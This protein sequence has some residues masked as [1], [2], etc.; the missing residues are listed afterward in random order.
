MENQEIMTKD[1]HI[2]AILVSYGSPIT[3]VDRTDRKKQVFYFTCLPH[4][5]FI[6]GEIGPVI[7]EISV[8]DDIISLYRSKRIFFPPS[9]VD[10]IRSVKAYIYS[11]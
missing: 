7:C 10:C 11:E 5:V 3:R 9:F 2:A 6:S 8:L 1:M 4:Q